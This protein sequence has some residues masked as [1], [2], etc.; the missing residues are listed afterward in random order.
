MR[1]SSRLILGA[2]KDHERRSAHVRHLYQWSNAKFLFRGRIVLLSQTYQSI[3]LGHSTYQNPSPLPNYTATH[4]QCRA[5]VWKTQI[6]RL[7]HDRECIITRITCYRA[8]YDVNK[9]DFY[10]VMS[11]AIVTDVGNSVGA[12]A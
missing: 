11:I 12:C 10:L 5:E 7:L 9:S 4:K 1:V 3:F 2:Q 8:S 6:R